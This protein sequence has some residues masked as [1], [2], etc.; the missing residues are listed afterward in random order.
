MEKQLPNVTLLAMISV[1][2][3]DIVRA[4]KHSLKILV[5]TFEIQKG[6]CVESETVFLYEVRSSLTI[7]E[8]LQFL[9]SLWIADGLMRILFCVASIKTKW[10]G[11][12]CD[13][14]PWKLQFGFRMR[15][16]YRKMKGS[17][18]LRFI[19]FGIRMKIT[20][21]IFSRLGFI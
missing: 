15:R 1:K 14:H 7:Q 13:G 9:G 21:S 2:I 19:S 6:I 18:H 8:K 11:R 4:L 17:H 10:K 16:I 3:G 12:G 5:V 20:R